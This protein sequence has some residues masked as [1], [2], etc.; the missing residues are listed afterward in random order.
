MLL[1]LSMPAENGLATLQRAF[2]RRSLSHGLLSSRL[3][4]IPK[5]SRKPPVPVSLG[6]WHTARGVLLAPLGGNSSE[7]AN[8]AGNGLSQRELFQGTGWRMRLPIRLLGPHSQS[9]RIGPL[10][11]LSAPIVTPE[12]RRQAIRAGQQ[13]ARA[14][15]KHMGRPKRVFDRREVIRLR[16]QE[17]LSFPEI[18][19]RIG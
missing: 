18:A 12:R 16:D 15:G 9:L 14:E 11:W 7:M 19:R 13:R 10:S 5:S 17:R 8:T 4:Q 6:S 2:V 3:R 1:D